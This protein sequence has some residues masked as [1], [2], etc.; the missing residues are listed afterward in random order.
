MSVD[1]EDGGDRLDSVD[2]IGTDFLLASQH[3]IRNRV[4]GHQDALHFI[5]DLP[6]VSVTPEQMLEILGMDPLLHLLDN[7]PDIDVFKLLQVEYLHL[8]KVGQ[9]RRKR[10]LELV[11]L[12]EVVRQPGDGSVHQVLDRRLD[13][14]VRIGL[15]PAVKDFIEQ[16]TAKHGNLAEYAEFFVPKHVGRDSELPGNS[17][18]C[19]L[20]DAVKER[21]RLAI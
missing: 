13:L 3:F 12:S 21:F 20:K 9:V 16:L 18:L 1:D 6:L 8:D 15:D 11:H 4:D 19:P 2:V 17:L 7:V 10:G 5:L 14:L